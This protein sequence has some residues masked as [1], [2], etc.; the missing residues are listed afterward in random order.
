M[1]KRLKMSDYEIDRNSMLHA[2]NSPRRWTLTGNKNLRRIVNTPGDAFVV[3]IGETCVSAHYKSQ[4]DDFWVTVAK[5]STIEAAK[6]AL[7]PCALDA[8]VDWR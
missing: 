5:E 1:G 2:W 4:D 6:A 3:A 7:L 8:G